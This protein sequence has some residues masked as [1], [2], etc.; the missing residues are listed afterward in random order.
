[1]TP[2]SKSISQNPNGGCY[3]KTKSSVQARAK[4]KIFPQHEHMEDRH[5]KP[6]LAVTP[7]S[8]NVHFRLLGLVPLAF[9]LA[10]AAH[11]WQ[12]NEVGHMFWMCN[13]GNLLLAIGLFFEHIL[14]IRVAIL[15][16]V[17]GFIIWILYVVMAWGM[18]FSSTLA[19]AGGLVIG[20]LVVRRVRMEESTWVYAL[21]WYL[22]IQVASRFLTPFELNVNVSHQIQ[23]GWEQAFSAYWQFWLVLTAGVALSLWIVGRIL[24]KF[25]PVPSKA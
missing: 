13:I 17:P 21:G 12:I 18:F 11:Y 5:S 23:P 8:S 14:L 15:W 7:L 2:N 4:C 20:L 25:C 22:I 24:A 1:V 6:D 9:F 19:H 16:M 3:S 10:Q